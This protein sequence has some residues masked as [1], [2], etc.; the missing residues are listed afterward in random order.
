MDEEGRAH[1][2]GDGFKV[3]QIA[4]A[5]LANDWS[6]EEIQR[7]HPH[8]TLSQVYNAACLLR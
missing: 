4:R 3:V 7:R 5:R 2:K 1:I 6:A 8:L